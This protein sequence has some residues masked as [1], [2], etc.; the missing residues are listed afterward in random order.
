M[1]GGAAPMTDEERP[2]TAPRTLAAQLWRAGQ[3]RAAIEDAVR[4][5]H[6]LTRAQAEIVVAE[7][8]AIE[9]FVAAGLD[10]SVVERQV[11]HLLAPTT[12]CA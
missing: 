4:S 3:P 11:D 9:R 7:Q 10:R 2:L 12:P 6:G 8:A 1:P 5:G